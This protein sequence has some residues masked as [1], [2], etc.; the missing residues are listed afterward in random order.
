MNVTSIGDLAYSLM[1][2]TRSTSLKQTISTLSEELSSG[3]ISDV[4][5]RVGGDYSYLVDIDRDLSRLN[6]FSVATSEAAIFFEAAQQNLERLADESVDLSTKILST[7][8]AYVT[9]VR[10]HNADIARDKIDAIL[11]SLNGT[12]AGQSLFSGIATDT[13]PLE[14]TD[15]LL[16]G[17]QAAISGQTTVAGIQAAA[18]AWFNNPAGFEA[19]MYAGSSTTLAPVEIS[20]GQAVSMPVTAN[21]QTF[22]D[23]LKNAA[24]AALATD[25]VLALSA[26]VQNDLMLASAEDMMATQDQLAAIQADIG[27]AQSRIDEATARNEASRSSLQLSRNLL[28]EADPFE[29]ATRLEDAQFQLESLFAV[30]V[31]NSRLTLLS[32]F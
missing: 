15:T 7:T 26:S 6:G 13:P 8:P 21:D 1:L 23:L 30:T 24:L 11:G 25:P 9:S 10:E 12:I 18:T 29:T 20:P 16:A 17:L 32:F 14:D 4:T 2:S 3:Q 5:E 22:R 28:L 27:F 31:R 19:L